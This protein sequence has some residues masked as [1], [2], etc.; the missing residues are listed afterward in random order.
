MK[1]QS[2]TNAQRAELKNYR[3]TKQL[4]GRLAAHPPALN[5]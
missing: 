2:I 1:S 3:T 5:D 4:R